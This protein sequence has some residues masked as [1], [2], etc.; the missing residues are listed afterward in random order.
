MLHPPLLLRLLL[1][2]VVIVVDSTENETGAEPLLDSFDAHIVVSVLT[3][4][5]SFAA[6]FETNSQDEGTTRSSSSYMSL[7]HNVSV[8]TCSICSLSGIYATVVFSLSSIYGRAAV[9]TGRM[10][11]Y[12]EFL[13]S[14]ETIRYKAFVMYLLSLILFIVLLVGTATEKIDQEYR[15][16][17][18]SFLLFLS[19]FS[20]N[21]WNTIIKCA[22]PIFTA[23]EDTNIQSHQQQQQPSQQQQQPSLGIKKKIMKTA[24]LSPQKEDS[25]TFQAPFKPHHRTE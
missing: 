1:L 4:T 21:D 25:S 6:L 3:A 15:I 24:H 7:L 19:I 16:Y 11:I 17:F 18:F 2:L 14:T 10:D 9:G 12:E 23:D 20:Y 5:A 22:G 13:K 8:L